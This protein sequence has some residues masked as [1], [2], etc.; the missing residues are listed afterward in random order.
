MPKSRINKAFQQNWNVV[1]SMSQDRDLYELD[2]REQSALVAMIEYLTWRTRWEGEFT[3]DEIKAF[4]A[5]VE[6]DVTNPID[7]CL[8][9]ADCIA[10]DSRVQ[11]ALRDWYDND[12]K[13]K[14]LNQSQLE[15]VLGYD[16]ECD[17]DVL[18]AQVFEI[19]N[20]ADEF[21]SQMFDTLAGA[22]TLQDIGSVIAALPGIDEMGVDA[23]TNMAKA[24]LEFPAASYNLDMSLTYREELACEIFC[25]LEC[26]VT[27]EDVWTV[28]NQRVTSAAPELS[29]DYDTAASMLFAIG[30]YAA[31][32]SALNKADLWYWALFGGLRYANVVYMSSQV[33]MKVFQVAAGL[34][35]D[36]PSNDWE[37]LCTACPAPWVYE[38]DLTGA[39]SYTS[40][41]HEATATAEWISGTGYRVTGDGFNYGAVFFDTT[42]IPVGT[43]FTGVEFD[44]N[45]SHSG[46]SLSQDYIYLVPDGYLTQ[47]IVGAGIG[48]TMSVFGSWTMS[49]GGTL[50][51]QVASNEA[52]ENTITIRKVRI[53]G[54]GERPELTGGAFLE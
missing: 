43:L 13:N 14:K 50:F 28:I 52:G 34:A 9:V 29:A 19:V 30:F 40:E 3:L 32:L 17:K 15:Q 21:L 2:Q 25:G 27:F 36:E 20:R 54:D 16:P 33:G 23:I 10:A 4:A 12:Y 46:D 8:K 26:Q 51:P 1:S 48:I 35:A 45:K 38:W 37:T 24:L 42:R 31:E 47:A 39:A 22:L 44:Y 7:Y 18:W 49:S 6:F 41:S 11:G 53:S 5:D